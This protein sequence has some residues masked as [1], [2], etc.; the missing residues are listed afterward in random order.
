MF[1][2]NRLKDFSMK[3]FRRSSTLPELQSTGYGSAHRKSPSSHSITGVPSNTD[4]L[5]ALKSHSA[6]SRSTNYSLVVQ[7]ILCCCLVLMLLGGLLSYTSVTTHERT[8][9]YHLMIT[10][11]YSEKQILDTTGV[12]EERSDRIPFAKPTLL[13]QATKA[14]QFQ[15]YDA[16]PLYS[17]DTLGGAKKKKRMMKMREE[18]ERLHTSETAESC[19][20]SDTVRLFVGI[21]S[22]ASV[23]A[24]TKRN[25]IRDAWLGDIGESF[26]DSVK[27]TFLVSQPNFKS[28][29]ELLNLA[30]DLID[31]YRLYKDIAVIPGPENYMALPIKTFSMMRYALSSTCQY[32]HVLKTDDDVYLRI[33]YLLDIIHLGIYHG[34]LKIQAK[35]ILD[36]HAKIKKVPKRK[37]STPWMTSMYIGKLDR[38]VTNTYPGFEPVRDPE[39]KWY[40]SEDSYP[41]ELGPDR[42][43]WI[44]GW[45]YLLSRDVVEHV[46]EEA[47]SIA[48]KEVHQR[49]A[50]WGRLPWEDVVVAT[51][52]R[53]YTDLYHHEGFK[54]AWDSCKN[55]TVLKHLDNQAPLLVAGL[56]EQDRTGLWDKK[57]VVCSA[58]E[59]EPGDYKTWK[60]WRNSLP[61]AKTVGKM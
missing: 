4:L 61:D 49:P 11:E 27:G 56:A 24:R 21:A 33:G 32:T 48:S 12:L 39:N 6:Q 22:R 35:S 29:G 43:R 50:W 55:D 53:D 45:G 58:G 28:Q 26:G 41:D 36:F 46:W 15:E 52:L 9:R 3:G 59:Y 2:T 57:E 16:V 8:A 20:S 40:L 31:E 34:V 10:R 47:E 38:N 25:A 7:S 19:P 1:T 23:R 14:L 44:S 54:A 17:T 5:R 51:L 60:R 30:D 13:V 42:I 18:M 37:E